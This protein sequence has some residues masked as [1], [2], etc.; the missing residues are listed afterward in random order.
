ENSIER[1]R[2]DYEFQIATLKKRVNDLESE[3]AESVNANGN[4]RI[5]SLENQ[6]EELLKI[7]EQQKSQLMLLEQEV[8]QLNEERQQQL[9]I[10]NDVKKEATSLLEEVKILSMKNEELSSEKERDS[11]KIQSLTKAVDEW[12]NKYENAKAEM[13][14]MNEVSFVDVDMLK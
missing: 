12:K 1:M 6:L 10:T 11:A 8:M 3:L 14:N 9:E 5:H 2:S 7:N 13:N 4:S